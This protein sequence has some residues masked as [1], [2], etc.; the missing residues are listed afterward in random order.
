MNSF[1]LH[2][3]PWTRDSYHLLLSN[4]RGERGYLIG[5]WPLALINGRAALTP[6]VCSQYSGQSTPVMSQLC[7]P[8]AQI[9][10]MA[11]FL[12]PTSEHLHVL[13]HQP[14]ASPQ[15]ISQ[16]TSSPPLPSF[17]GHLLSEAFPDYLG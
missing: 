14:G 13:L 7:H 4:T 9:P 1:N 12:A 5:T 10:P 11:P 6:L 16:L 8:Y 2:T 3:N 17:K 15:I